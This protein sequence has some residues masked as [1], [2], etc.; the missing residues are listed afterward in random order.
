MKRCLLRKDFDAYEF[1]DDWE[2]FDG[3]SLPG[4]KKEFYSN[5]NVDGITDS[6]YSHMKRIFQSFR[7][8]HLGE[9]IIS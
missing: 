9:I 2:N 5:L 6:D 8:K 4:K 1:K 7:T 3:K